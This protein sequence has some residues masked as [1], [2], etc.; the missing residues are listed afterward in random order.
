MRR[1]PTPVISRWLAREFRWSRFFYAS[2]IVT[3][4]TEPGTSIRYRA[5]AHPAA[6]F[7][8]RYSY[9][10]YVFQNE[11]AHVLVRRGFSVPLWRT[12]T[13][14]AVAAQPIH[15]TV[16]FT[17]SLAIAV[18]SWHLF[19]SQVLKLKSRFRYDRA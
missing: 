16:G 4:L 2:L 5:L 11:V 6:R 13:G 15:T 19:E 8:G 3:C 12:Y 17:I 18:A 10:L 7:V 9:G 1:P 14:S